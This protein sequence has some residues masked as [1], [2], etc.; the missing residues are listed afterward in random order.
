M[1]SHKFEYSYQECLACGNC[2][3]SYSTEETLFVKCNAAKEE[4]S[5]DKKSEYH[6]ACRDYKPRQ[7][8]K[9]TEN[10]NHT[11][12]PGRDF[13]Y[14]KSVPGALIGKFVKHKNEKYKV[15]GDLRL[16]H[17]IQDDEW[18]PI[19]ICKEDNIKTVN[20]LNVN[21]VVEWIEPEAL[22]ER[23]VYLYTTASNQTC[24]A[25]ILLT[26]KDAEERCNGYNHILH[27]WPVGQVY[28]FNKAGELVE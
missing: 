25:D 12:L 22:E 8:P 5:Q 6:V 17:K 16:V 21:E 18:H 20:S 27:K 2:R 14:L 15:F 3:H 9:M 23:A 1:T 7:E 28:K 26:K 11:S 24:I 4:L 13:E 19:R 10:P